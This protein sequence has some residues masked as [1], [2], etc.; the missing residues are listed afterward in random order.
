MEPLAPKG[1]A[2]GTKGDGATGRDEGTGIGA[3][4]GK[5]AIAGSITEGGTLDVGTLGGGTGIDEVIE[6]SIGIEGGK[7]DAAAGTAE[8]TGI[9]KAARGI[10]GGG[11]TDV[12]ATIAG[13]TKEGTTAGG[14]PAET[15]TNAAVGG[16]ASGG[17]G[18]VKPGWLI[19][20]VE[21]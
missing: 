4:N 11:I 6:L 17:A 13:R 5:E 19:P 20:N 14:I 10:M 3:I 21:I 7:C 16:T 15:A 9:G 1:R 2:G 8:A 12:G 18:M